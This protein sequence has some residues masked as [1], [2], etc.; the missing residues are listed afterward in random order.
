MP[1]TE[2][3]ANIRVAE[4]NRVAL[5][6]IA[7]PGFLVLFFGILFCA[8]LSSHMLQQRADGLY[9]G[10]STWG[11][12]AWHLSMIS[13][14]AQRGLGAVR[15]NPVFPRTK[16]SYPF[17]PDLFSAWLITKGVSLQASLIWP[18]L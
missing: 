1:A 7:V 3:A 15:E 10:G 13:N 9:S 12:L 4:G 18:T 2:V 5:L 16:L 17:L 8:L 14:F 6:D 11:D